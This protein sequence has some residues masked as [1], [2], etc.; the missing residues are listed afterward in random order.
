MIYILGHCLH[1]DNVDLDQ[2]PYSATALFVYSVADVHYGDANFCIN[3]AVL[4]LKKMYNL[5]FHG[6]TCGNNI[7]LFNSSRPIRSSNLATKIMKIPN[8]PTGTQR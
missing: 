6:S 7:C 8:I 2:L 4:E 5:I 1:N 3:F